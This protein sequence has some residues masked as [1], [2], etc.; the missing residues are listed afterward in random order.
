MKP[1]PRHR[2]PRAPA[3]TLDNIPLGLEA[4][5]RDLDQLGEDLRRELAEAGPGMGPLGTMGL[6][7]TLDR[8][9]T[10]AHAARG[11]AAKWRS[12]LD[13]SRAANPPLAN[14]DAI[15]IDLTLRF[16]LGIPYP[17]TQALPDTEMGRY[18]A[19]RLSRRSYRTYGITL[20]PGQVD[21]A[22]PRPPSPKGAPE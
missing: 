8:I 9:E 18:A 5:A 3:E 17:S 22:W 11:I 19:L 2:D 12:A 7:R 4:M 21:A 14:G 16:L 6:R 10:Q 20:D 13:A 1:D 15:D